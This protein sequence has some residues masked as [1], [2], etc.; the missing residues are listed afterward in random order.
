MPALFKPGEHYIGKGKVP[1]VH[2][3]LID[4]NTRIKSN[5]VAGMQE[6]AKAF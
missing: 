2:F 6:R 4:E 5:C 1:W 3:Q